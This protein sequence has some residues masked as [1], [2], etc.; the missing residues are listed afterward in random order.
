MAS[1]RVIASRYSKA[2]F[3]FLETGPKKEILDSLDGL[4]KLIRDSSELKTILESPA[5]T[6]KE[7][8]EILKEVL[9]LM[10][11]PSSVVEFVRVLVDAKRIEVLAEIVSDFRERVL[12]EEGAVEGLV[13]TASPLSE[14]DLEGLRKIVETLFRKKVVFKSRINPK[15]IAGVRVHVMGKTLDTSLES[16]LQAM[17]RKLLQAEA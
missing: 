3:G 5:F 13:E 12:K 9:A 6:P 4:E 2:L 16:S 11:L 14:S 17:H 1:P 8:W 10:K 15:L 7:K